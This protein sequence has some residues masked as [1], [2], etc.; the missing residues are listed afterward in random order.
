[1]LN[2]IFSSVRR[3]A[4]HR[5]SAVT[6][7]RLQYPAS[8]LERATT[9]CFLDHHEK[10]FGRKKIA[11]PEVERRSSGSNQKPSQHDCNHGV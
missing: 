10:R 7:A 6:K 2:G 8:I 4:S 1:D 5:T 9:V 11:A 3:V